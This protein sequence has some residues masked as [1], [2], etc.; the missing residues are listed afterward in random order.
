MRQ[1]NGDKG[2]KG[3]KCHK[4]QERTFQKPL[5]PLWPLWPFPLPFPKKTTLSHEETGSESGP[6]LAELQG[7]GAGLLERHDDR[8]TTA[9]SSE[10]NHVRFVVRLATVGDFDLRVGIERADAAGT[11]AEPEARSGRRGAVGR[12]DGQAASVFVDSDRGLEDLC[13]I[14]DDLL[15]AAEDERL[16]AAPDVDEQLLE[17]NGRIGH[18]DRGGTR[19]RHRIRRGLAAFVGLSV[20]VL[21]DAVAGAVGLAGLRHAGVDVLVFVVAVALLGGAVT[22]AIAVVVDTV[23]RRLAERLVVAT[24]ILV[25]HALGVALT[26]E[27]LVVRAAAPTFARRGRRRAGVAAGGR[28]VGVGGRVDRGGRVVLVDVE[29]LMRAAGEETEGQDQTGEEIAHERHSCRTLARATFCCPALTPEQLPAFTETISAA[30]G[31][32][33]IQ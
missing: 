21:V 33:S 3:N 32:T 23:A 26:G 1:N 8:A 5:Q 13:R 9:G 16:A 27:R 10:R 18:L 24:T 19:G 14:V 31:Q 7:A 12:L 15:V 11:G 30:S 6:K 29:R 20:A 2:F 17:A 4:G 28:R 22:V 25:G